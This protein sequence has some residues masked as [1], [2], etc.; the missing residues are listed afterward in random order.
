MTRI[1]RIVVYTLMLAL[2]LFIAVLFL[3]SCQVPLR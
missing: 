3:S 2:L 1:E